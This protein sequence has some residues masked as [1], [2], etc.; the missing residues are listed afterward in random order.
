VL[1]VWLRFVR[2]PATQR[3]LLA[4]STAAV[5]AFVVFDHVLSPQ[6]LIW[7]APLVVALPGRRGLA[8][9]GLLALAMALTQIWIPARFWQLTRFEAVPSWAVLG[10]DLVLLALLATLAWLDVPNR[11]SAPIGQRA[12]ETASAA[13]SL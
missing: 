11:S 6:Y 3:R 7:L 4:A 10:R 8:A 5:C 2:C 9:T 13:G 1:V 12:P